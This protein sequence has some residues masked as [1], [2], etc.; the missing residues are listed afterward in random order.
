MEN[1]HNCNAGNTGYAGNTGNTGNIG[2]QDLASR[3]IL[4]SDSYSGSRTFLAGNYNIS[5]IT[6]FSHVTTWITHTSTLVYI[7]VFL[8]H[9]EYS[10]SIF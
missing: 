3:T 8:S 2:K 7:Y 1:G 4:H 10:V 9:N 6:Q 5:I